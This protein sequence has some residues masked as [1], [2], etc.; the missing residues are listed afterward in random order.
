MRLLTWNVQE[1]GP[2]R[3]RDQ[4]EV[5]LERE[6]DLI[7][8]QAVSTSGYQE[9]RAGLGRAGYS[10]VDSVDLAR[11]AYPPPPYPKGIKQRQINRGGFALTAARHE[12]VA[13]QGLHFD[14]PEERRFAFPEKFI[15]AE[16]AVS[17]RVIEVHNAGAPPRFI[18]TH[19][20]AAGPRRGRSLAG[21]A[22]AGTADPLR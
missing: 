9:W 6:A 3:V 22:S 14:D 13:L 19:P 11:V 20:Q 21:G 7:A 12:S 15:A 5:L 8:L 1:S 16:M 18:A 2:R 17:E 10:V 4:L